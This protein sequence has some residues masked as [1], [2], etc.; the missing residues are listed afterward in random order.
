MG[1]R[2]GS[3][4]TPCA[5]KTA[6]VPRRFAHSSRSV[7]T[8]DSGINTLAVGA[9]YRMK[10]RP[11]SLCSRA[12]VAGR[13]SQPCLRRCDHRLEARIIADRIEIG[14]YLCVVYETGADSL[15]DRPDHVQRRVEVL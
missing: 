8:G 9:P 6:A 11:G 1:L 4:I 5:Q 10:V 13:G 12:S 3:A 14:V 2:L 7:A 15:Q